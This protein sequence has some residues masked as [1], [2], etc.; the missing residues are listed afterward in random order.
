MEELCRI[1]EYPCQAF[2]HL[3]TAKSAVQSATIEGGPSR[4]PSMDSTGS[5][6]EG[7]PGT[8]GQDWRSRAL[9][10]S[11]GN[12][13]SKSGLSNAEAPARVV[14][15]GSTWLERGLPPQWQEDG[16]VVVLTSAPEEF[17]EVGRTLLASG[18]AEIRERLRDRGINDYLMHPL[19][20]ESLKIVVQQAIRRK[21]GDEYLLLQALGRGASG[22]VHQAK[23]L[24]DGESFALKEIN[25]RRLSRTAK[26]DVERETQLL[27]ELSWPTVVFVVDAWDSTVDHIRFLLMPLLLGGN[28]L[29]RAEAAAS[30]EDSQKI[31]SGRVAEWY[32]QTLHGLCYLHWRGVLH[33]DVKPGNLLLAADQQALQIGDLGSAA[34]LPGPGP[35]PAKANMVRGMVC[36]PAY[37]SPEVLLQGT[38]MSASDIWSVGAS[39]YEVCTLKPLVPSGAPMGEIKEMV[40]NFVPERMSELRLPMVDLTDLLRQDPLRRPSAAK[41]ASQPTTARRIRTVLA[42]CGALPEEEARKAHFDLFHRVLSESE[43]AAD[44]PAPAETP[45]AAGSE[46]RQA[47]RRAASIQ[48]AEA[49][50]SQQSTL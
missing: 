13:K 42:E 3:T 39:F 34:L 41:L 10:S 35:H 20:L 23:R 8:E 37:A 46:T 4:R 29:Q 50:G 40:K 27:Q 22:I 48:R 11:S 15:L 16:V 5:L 30:G 33:R 31:P 6:L 47:R 1:L 44:L 25:T 7:R 18:E 2:R 17:E 45:K 14:L 26:Q 9:A 28:L 12:S 21:F 43:A 38:Y 49:E 36:T 32:A 19:S 24:K